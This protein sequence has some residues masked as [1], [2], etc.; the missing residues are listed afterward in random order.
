MEGGGRGCME[1]KP[2]GGRRRLLAGCVW[3]RLLIGCRGWGGFSLAERGGGPPGSLGASCCP[4][5]GE[6]A[7][8][9]EAVPTAVPARS[10]L[11]GS[12]SGAAAGEAAEAPWSP[13]FRPGGGAARRPRRGGCVRE[14]AASPRAWRVAAPGPRARGAPVPRLRL[15]PASWTTPCARPWPRPGPAP[16]VAPRDPDVAVPT[17]PAG[18]GARGRPRGLGGLC[19]GLAPVTGTR[20]Q[21]RRTRAAASGPTALA[22][23]APPPPAPW[24]WA[25]RAPRTPRAPRL[26]PAEAPRRPPP[27]PVLRGAAAAVSVLPPPCEPRGSP[28]NS[29]GAWTRDCPGG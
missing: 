2:I 29:L 6:A 22:A 28:R 27:G 24:F 20:N 8:P 14:H 12:G 21:R 11:L 17:A 3:R 18:L 16:R 7:F 1:G 4:G 5:P 19:G 26:R 9:P 15:P 23:E 13:G 10:P 25:P